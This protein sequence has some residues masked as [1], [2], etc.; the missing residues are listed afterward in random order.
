M[1]VQDLKDKM[2]TFERICESTINSLQDSDIEVTDVSV[3]RIEITTKEHSRP[4]FIWEVRIQT[5]ITT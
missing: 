4:Q 1:T 3:E 5:K 2:S